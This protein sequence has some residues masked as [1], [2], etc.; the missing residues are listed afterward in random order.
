MLYQLLGHDALAARLDLAALQIYRRQLDLTAAV[1]SQC[2]QLIL[3]KDAREVLRGL[4]SAAD[5]AKQ[6]LD[7]VYGEVL[8]WKGS[9][10]VRQQAIRRMI[11]A[12]KSPAAAKL[13]AELKHKSQALASLSMSVAEPAGEKERLDRLAQLTDDVEGAEHALAAE[14]AAFRKQLDFQRIAPADVQQALPDSAALIDL[15]EYFR[16]LRPE[17]RTGM[18]HWDFCLTAFIVRRDRKLERVE[19]GPVPP[20]YEAIRLWRKAFVPLTADEAPLKSDPA[21][22][23]KADVSKRLRE[24]IWDKLDSHLA[25]A[26]IVLVSPDGITARFPWS[27]MPGKEPGTYLIEDVAIG[28][29][30]IPRLLAQ[31]RLARPQ[32]DNPV[33]KSVVADRQSSREPSLLVVGDVDY[34]ADPATAPATTIGGTAPRATRSGAMVHWPA[35]EGTRAELAAIADAFEQRFPEGKLE[36]LSGGRATKKT[37]IADMEF[38]R[39]VHLATHG[40]FAPKELQSAL[41]LSEATAAGGAVV[42]RN[43]FRSAIDRNS[44]HSQIGYPPGLLSGLVLAGANQPA[45]EGRDDGVL[46]ALEVA[47]LNLDDVDLAT[48]SACE[49]GLGGMTK[50][51][52]ILG[53]QRAFQIAG[54]KSVV[55][56]LW[57]I[58]DDA[59]CALMTDFYDN[60]WQK[61]M[62][63]IEALRQAQLKMLRTGVSHIDNVAGRAAASAASRG[64]KF[65][66]DQL[67]PDENRRLPPYYWAPFVLSGDWR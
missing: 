14:S 9:V 6:P 40:F 16:Y 45:A 53:L 15:V 3:L 39:Y 17:E 8:A 34:D 19:L 59:T 57:R 60:L 21:L 37:L 27:A 62:P 22:R 2:Q 50:G 51:E 28:V 64:L 24:L 47:Q 49:T 1:Q 67:Q 38:H 31:S 13:V 41:D 32:L 35:L 7:E 46:T 20:I 65:T 43:S 12:E 44:S 63:K 10:A 29:V 25:G 11:A 26:K 4:L 54:A 52:G 66:D 36:K 42:E 48:L 61:K 30:P 58:N 18:S 5:G 33:R 56:T 55:T 23:D